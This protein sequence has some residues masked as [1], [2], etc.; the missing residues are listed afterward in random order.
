MILHLT[1]RLFVFEK[2]VSE[3][4]KLPDTSHNGKHNQIS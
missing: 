3:Q 1:H 2:P 4:Q